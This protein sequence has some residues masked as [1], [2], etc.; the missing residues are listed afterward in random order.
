MRS[1]DA[2]DTNKALLLACVEYT[3]DTHVFQF[4]GANTA[5]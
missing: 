1:H 2:D 5:D 3:S 4:H